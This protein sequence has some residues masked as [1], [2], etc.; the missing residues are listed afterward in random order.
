LIPKDL[1]DGPIRGIELYPLQRMMLGS[2]AAQGIFFSRRPGHVDAPVLPE[3]RTGS[4]FKSRFSI[5][6][7]RPNELGKGFN[8]SAHTFIDSNE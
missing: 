2:E 6:H 4:G 3:L 1:L 7:L 5:S 8:G